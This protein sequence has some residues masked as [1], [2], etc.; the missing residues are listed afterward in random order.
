MVL[1]GSLSAPA[2]QLQNVINFNGGVGDTVYGVTSY[3]GGAQVTPKFIGN[4]VTG[5]NDILASPGG[6]YQLANPVIANNIA[7]FGPFATTFSSFQIGG[8]NGNGAFGAGSTVVTGPAIGFQLADSGP[9]GGEASYMISSWTSNFTVG[10]GGFNGNLGSYLGIA[11]VLPAIGSA[12]VAS[13]VT[14]LSINGG[15]FA[16]ETPLI[17][18]AAGNLS[19]VALGG[20]GAAVLYGPGGT[21]RGL[22]IDNFGNF[23]LAGGSTITAITTLTAYADPAMV[24]SLIFDPALDA[25]LL[26]ATGASLPGTVL[27]SDSAAPEPATFALFAGALAALAFTGRK[28]LKPFAEQ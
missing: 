16:L 22:S 28:R 7:Q 8:G 14:E 17:L 5:Y 15:P 21:Y 20:A 11:G 19:T 23:V 3:G 9:A 27:T 24:D 26:A 12:A 25:D 4:N 2:A 1:A 10:A 18:A 6:T 13:M